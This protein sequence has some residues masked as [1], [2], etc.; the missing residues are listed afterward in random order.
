MKDVSKYYLNVKNA[1]WDF[2]SNFNFFGST[3]NLA[4]V[5]LIC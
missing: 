2:G 5:F 4:K 1:S 3:F